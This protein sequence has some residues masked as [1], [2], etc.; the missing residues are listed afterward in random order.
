MLMITECYEPCD[1]KLKTCNFIT[2]KIYGN[3][4]NDTSD[5]QRLD[6]AAGSIIYNNFNLNMLQMHFFHFFVFIFLLHEKGIFTRIPPAALNA[7][8]LAYVKSFLCNVQYLN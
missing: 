6:E 7:V 2:Y 8:C 5:I 1:A 3:N 4:N